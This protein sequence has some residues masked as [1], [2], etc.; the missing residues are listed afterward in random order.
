MKKVVLVLAMAFF[1]AGC[2]G[3]QV[4]NTQ[5]PTPTPD[6]TM[7]SNTNAYV[8]DT[9]GWPDSHTLAVISVDPSVKGLI[10]AGPGFHYV[11]VEVAFQAIQEIEYNQIFDFELHDSSGF[12][13]SV[14]V[15]G[16]KEPSLGSGTLRPGK[17]ARG[18]VVFEVA[19][20]AKGLELWYEQFLVGNYGVWDLGL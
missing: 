3:S 6:P 12:T 14:A 17:I 8:G 19:D 10:D 11:A 5:A 7:P 20:G 9:L 18:W 16:D 2:G 4:V 15:F 13:Y 1:L